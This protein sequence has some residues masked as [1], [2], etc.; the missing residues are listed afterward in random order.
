MRVLRS[1][2]SRLKGRT[3]RPSFDKATFLF[4]TRYLFSKK[5]SLCYLIDFSENYSGTNSAPFL[6][7][8]VKLPKP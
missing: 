2:A 1:C 5:I 6:N 3:S 4:L 7:A 8:A